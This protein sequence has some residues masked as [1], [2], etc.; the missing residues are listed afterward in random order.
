MEGHCFLPQSEIL[1]TL[2]VGL[3]FWQRQATTPTPPTKPPEGGDQLRARR[4]PRPSGGDN[5]RKSLRFCMG[6]PQASPYRGLPEVAG[7]EDEV[8]RTPFVMLEASLGL[9][10]N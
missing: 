6:S 9:T 1:E 8:F 10:Q 4:G 5:D 7:E 2:G 3:C